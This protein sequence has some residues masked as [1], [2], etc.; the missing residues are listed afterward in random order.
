MERPWRGH[1]G[2]GRPARP[3][4]ARLAVGSDHPRHLPVRDTWLRQ[5]V[6]SR[7]S[8]LRR[9]LVLL[10]VSLGSAVAL[11]R[12]APSAAEPNDTSYLPVSSAAVHFSHTARPL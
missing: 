10:V 5:Q 3:A 2:P 4:T 6:S 7:A 8:E 1:N 11:P 12:V 9:F